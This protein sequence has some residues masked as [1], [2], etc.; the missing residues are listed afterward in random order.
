MRASKTI[1][2]IGRNEE[3]S[4]R[5]GSQVKLCWI[6]PASLQLL[7]SNQRGHQSI[8]WLTAPVITM[9][10]GQ[11]LNSRLNDRIWMMESVPLGSLFPSSIWHSQLEVHLNLATTVAIRRE[12]NQLKAVMRYLWLVSESVVSLE[13]LS[14]K[15]KNCFSLETMWSLYFNLPWGVWCWWWWAE[16]EFPNDVRCGWGRCDEEERGPRREGEVSTV[17]GLWMFPELL[18]LLLTVAN[19]SDVEDEGV[20]EV[21]EEVSFWPKQFWKTCT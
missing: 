4:S 3:L 6:L 21:E 9:A 8:R 20:V 5:N 16:L 19:W 1:D 14:L 13:R 10:A 11:T 2:A 17:D 18:L 7:V 12:G 15:M